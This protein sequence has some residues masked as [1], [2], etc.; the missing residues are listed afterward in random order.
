MLV[1]VDRWQRIYTERVGWGVGTMGQMSKAIVEVDRLQ[2]IY[3]ERL[4]VKVGGWVP[5]VR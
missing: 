4:V 3:T 5:W 2:R 1:E